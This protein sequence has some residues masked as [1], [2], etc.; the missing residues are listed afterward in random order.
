MTNQ[1]LEPG[2]SA[3]LQALIEEGS[4]IFHEFDLQHRQRQWHPFVAA[5]YSDVLQIL[6]PLRQPGSMFLEWGSATGVITIM[7]DMLGFQA[8]GIEIDAPLVDIARGLAAKYESGATF[9]AGSFL[10]MGYEWRD[11]T[12]DRRT[13]TVGEGVSGYLEL[14]HPLEDFDIVFGYPWPGEAEIMKD[15]MQRYGRPDARLILHK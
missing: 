7:A 4:D 11:P 10:P 6:L 15:V 13:G 12:G 1:Q 2:L 3:R 9:A 14:Q 8:Y 5:N